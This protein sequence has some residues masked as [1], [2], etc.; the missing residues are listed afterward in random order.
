MYRL[1]PPV[2]APLPICVLKNGMRVR[3]TKLDSGIDELRA[4]AAGADHDERALGRKDHLGRAIEGRRM[5]DRA[6]DRM[7]GHDRRV[8]RI[9]LLRRDVLRQFEVHR[10][11]PFLHRDPERIAHDG[12]ECWPR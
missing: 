1:D 7:D 3:R 5:G 6:L 11:R 9:D 4:V 2:T 10:A 8:S 12:R